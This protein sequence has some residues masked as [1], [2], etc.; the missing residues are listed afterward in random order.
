MI[1][2]ADQQTF[3]AAAVAGE[4][5][6][7]V[8]PA[9]TSL[10][11]HDFA[12]GITRGQG[13]EL[14]QEVE[15]FV[16][17]R[18]HRAFSTDARNDDVCRQA[19]TSGRSAVAV[20]VASR[21]APSG[22]LI[23]VFTPN[24][25]RSSTFDVEPILTAMRATAALLG[26]RAR[27]VAERDKALDGARTVG[28]ELDL[29]YR[30]DKTVHGLSRRHAGLAELVG[31]SGRFLGVG[32]SVLMLPSKRIRISAT[33]SSWKSIN[34]RG[35]D[36]YIVESLMPR[37]TETSHPVVYDIDPVA[38]SEKF[39]DGRVQALV[40][41]LTD[42]RGNLEGVIAQLG[43]VN[44]ARFGSAEKRFMGQVM[45]KAQYVIEQS[46]DPMTGLMNRAGFEAQL[47][48]S[49]RGLEDEQHHQ[50]VY[51]DLDNLQLVNDSFGR[52]AGDQV[53]SRFARLVDECLPR[54]A[55]ASRLT[56]DDFA[57]LLT[58]ASL[59]DAMAVANAVRDRGDCLRFLSGTSSLQ[60]SVSVGIAS[61]VADGNV[62]DALTAARIACD[63]AKDHGR[64]RV[65]VHDQDDQS[66][67]RRYDDMQLVTRIQRALDNDEFVLLAQPIVDAKSVDRTSHYEILLRVS[68]AS[69]N[70]LS[71]ASFISAAERYHLMPQIDRWV[72][73]A[74]IRLIAEEADRLAGL[75][76]SFAINLSGQSIGDDHMLSFIE[77]EIDAAGIPERLLSFEITESAAVSKLDKAQAFVERLRRRGCRFSLDDFGVGLSSFT[78][79]KNLEVDALKIDGGFIRDITTDRISRSMVAA[80]VQV[81]AV[82]NLTT[83]AEYVGDRETQQ[84]LASLGVDY[85][86]GHGVGRPV[87]LRSVLAEPPT[88]A[89]QSA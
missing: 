31:Q 11:V 86:Q 79:L 64:D 53:I 44:G 18:L 26:D 59:D 14:D 16:A 49:I 40:S 66:I 73:A 47:R 30:L 81:A 10:H 83:I 51:F 6:A 33:H 45:R 15:H 22:A 75:D 82:M 43:R 19:L 23:A 3:D 63:T 29:V 36:R 58:D 54:N 50:I 80:I 68:D 21:S 84:L 9:G 24:A 39:F 38:T 89:R 85:L 27:L 71:P 62:S 12:D 67:I 20:P 42:S 34:R 4:L 48:D 72:I 78:Y 87:E 13:G 41:P 17:D 69:G 52:D 2:R 7:A 77:A 8:L 37:I 60:V 55:I 61:V 5:L 88:V 65:E 35:V 46:F 74:A 76:M 25:Q 32:Y 56:G 70:V 28:A 57:I 1:D